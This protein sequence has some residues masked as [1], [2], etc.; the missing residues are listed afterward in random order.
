[1]ASSG[2]RKS[3]HQTGALINSG[4][5]QAPWHGFQ[6][7]LLGAAGTKTRKLGPVPHHFII[8]KRESDERFLRFDALPFTRYS[9]SSLIGSGDH[10]VLSGNFIFT[11]YLLRR[12]IENHEEI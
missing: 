1:M 12:S 9:A 11:L 4:Y 2:E 6:R 7:L 5:P 10:F 3:L 8:T